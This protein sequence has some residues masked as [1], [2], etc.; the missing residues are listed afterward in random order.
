[1]E[2]ATANEIVKQ[3]TERNKRFIVLIDGNSVDLF[4]TGMLLQ[5]LE[6]NVYTSSTA[7]EALEI[8]KVATPSLVITEI[9]LNGMNGVDFLKRIRQ[10]PRLR[11]VPVIIYTAAKNAVQEAFCRREGCA[12]YLI[13]PAEPDVL[14]AAIQQATESQPRKFI[15]LKTCLTLVMGAGAAQETFSAQCV[16]A[17]SEDGMY[18]D[19]LTPLPVGTA[20]PVSITVYK[21]PVKIEGVVLYSHSAGRGPHKQPGMGV[22]FVK[23]SYE[24]K[25]LLR[26]YIKEQL[27]ENIVPPGRGTV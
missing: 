15:R 19:T 27:M 9:R 1:M 11:E 6:Y 22:K 13:K 26:Q 4:S 17:L 12:S 23:I 10:D 5:R 21:R 25:L 3:F 16:T 14:Y 2:E 20:V 7:E 24:D 18:V 8:M